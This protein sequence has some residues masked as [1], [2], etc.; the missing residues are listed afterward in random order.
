MTIKCLY[1]CTLCDLV[2]VAVE[3]PA[4][5][6]TQAVVEWMERICIPAIAN[7]HRRRSPAC[8]PDTLENLKI[9]ISNADYIGGPAVQ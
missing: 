1:T 7:D 9:P 3:V 2:D 8:N 6:S 4:R 5:A